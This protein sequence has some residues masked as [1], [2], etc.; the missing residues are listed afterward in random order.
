MIIGNLVKVYG[1][2]K[3]LG[4]VLKIENSQIKCIWCDGTI[5]WRGVWILEVVNE[6]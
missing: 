5:S 1:K 2:G 6:N 3:N 4:I